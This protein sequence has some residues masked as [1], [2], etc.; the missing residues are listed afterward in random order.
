MTR[1]LLITA[2]LVAALATPALAAKAG[3]KP[4]TLPGGLTYVQQTPGK[5]DPAKAGETVSMT[6]VGSFPGGK[7]FDESTDPN[8]PFTFVLG[9]QKVIACWEEGVLGMKLGETRK[10]T[11]PPALA[12]GQRGAGG[13]LIPPNATLQFVVTRVPKKP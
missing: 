11:C 5:G 13:G 9:Q 1:P 6:Y 10:L 4:V 7:V 3:P 2:A 8:K 12:Y